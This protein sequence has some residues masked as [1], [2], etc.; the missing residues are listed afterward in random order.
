VA[1]LPDLSDAT[2]AEVGAVVGRWR[3]RGAVVVVSVHWGSN[4]GYPVPRE[5]VRFAHRLVDAGAAVVHGH[6]SH[7]PRPPEVYAGRL[8]L[9]GCGDLVNDYEGIGGHEEYRSDLRLL[10]R[11]TVAPDGALLT[12]DLLPFRSRRMRLEHAAPA[13]AAWLADVLDRE[14]RSRGAHLTLRAGDRIGLGRP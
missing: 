6:S 11:A 9:Y 12:A 5:Q 13:D 1:L 4:W 14:S 10:H 2:A 3:R 7:H 8:V